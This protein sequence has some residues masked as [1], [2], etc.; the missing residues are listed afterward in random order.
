MNKKELI[1]NHCE[2]L[3][4]MVVYKTKKE[5]INDIYIYMLSNWS[6]SKSYIYKT[7]KDFIY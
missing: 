3:T 1:E 6:T 5:L 7:L 2:F 4:A